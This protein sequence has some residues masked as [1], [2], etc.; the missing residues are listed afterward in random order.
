MIRIIKMNKNEEKL[1]LKNHH[2]ISYY[3]VSIFFFHKFL[4]TFSLMK[5]VSP[6]SRVMGP[7]SDSNNMNPKL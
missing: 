4:L 7:T 3:I 2:H 6:L 1:T 5:N